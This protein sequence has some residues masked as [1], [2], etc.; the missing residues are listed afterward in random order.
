MP[1][2]LFIRPIH[3]KTEIKPDPVLMKKILSEGW[4]GQKKIHG[5]RAQVHLSA[6]STEGTIVYN[7]HGKPHGVK[8][9]K[10][11]EEELR[12]ILPLKNGWST[13]DAEWVKPLNKLFIFDML[14]LNGQ[15]L[16]TSTY[17]DRYQLLPQVYV[18]QYVETLP[19]ISQV[20]KC[21]EVMETTDPLIEGLVFKS[22]KTRGFS[23]SSVVRCRKANR[24]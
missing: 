9:S 21:Q 4:W 13:V 5:H 23:D 22:R 15:L 1:D 20:A 12:R 2:S 19:V 7:R 17:E 14:K 10:E 24:Q 3:P 16:N 11:I 8:L 6:N 18:S